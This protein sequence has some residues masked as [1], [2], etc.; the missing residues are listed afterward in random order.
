MSVKSSKKAAMRGVRKTKVVQDT[1]AKNHAV[2][3]A[4]VFKRYV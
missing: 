2:L 4:Q 3:P 1:N